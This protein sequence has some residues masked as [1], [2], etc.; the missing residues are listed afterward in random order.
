MRPP[1][2]K[3]PPFDNSERGRQR[4][5]EGRVRFT[6]FR[7]DSHKTCAQIRNTRRFYSKHT[8]EREGT[9]VYTGGGRLDGLQEH[10]DRSSRDTFT[11][12]VTRIG[13]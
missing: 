6:L 12:H 5:R 7:C 2:Q 3:F 13:T 11:D 8:G 1:Q 9:P 10:V 4:F